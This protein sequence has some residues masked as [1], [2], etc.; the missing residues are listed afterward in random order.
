MTAAVIGMSLTA[1]SHAR[2]DAHECSS[3]AESGQTL[4]AAG[5]WLDAR[6][7]FLACSASSCPTVVRADCARWAAEIVDAI[8]TI[9]VDARD[10][11]GKDLTDVTV[12]VDGKVVATKLDGRGIAVDP[13]PHKLHFEVAGQPPVDD[14]VVAKEQ[15]KGRR[16]AVTFGS[17]NQ[18]AQ[19]PTD[20]PPESPPREHSVL[21]WIIVGVGVVVVV[22]G[23]VVYFT[24]P[25][26]PRNCSDQTNVCMPPPTG[27]TLVADQDQAA[28]RRNR[29]FAGG[30][31]IGVGIA[32]IAGGLVW[33]F[34]EPTG[35]RKTS[36]HA[37]V[38]P[39]LGGLAVD[40]WF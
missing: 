5:R 10:A 25:P 22:S 34:L 7:K 35:P 29:R 23:A 20:A 28:R 17:P 13:G 9:V 6:E 19:A 12:S 14:E 27:P 30:V 2:A 8:P 26:L 15:M 18:A 4:R 21:P 39:T 33:H 40:G 1:A 31:T 24:A 32:S 11:S 16:I 37:R 3:A 36:A 38:V